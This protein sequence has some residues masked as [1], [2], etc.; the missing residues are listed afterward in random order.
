VRR[1]P[2]TGTI[3]RLARGWLARLP[4]EPRTHLGLFSTYEEAEAVLGAA[5]EAMAQGRVTTGRTLL[6]YGRHVLDQRELDGYRG[7]GRERR[8]WENYV[9]TWDAGARPVGACTR[10]VIRAWVLELRGRLA[11]Q[12]VANALN[13]LR[14]VLRRAVEDDLVDH[15]AA[16]DVDLRRHGRTE[17][18]ST[19]LT[20]AELE[21]LLYASDPEGRHLIAVA[22]WTGMRQGEVRSLRVQDVSLE[23][24]SPHL[25]V[26]HGS[27]GKPTKS[28][29]IRRVPLFGRALVALQS[30]K[31]PANDRG[32]VFPTRTGAVRCA[33]RMVEPEDWR[34]WLK[35]ARITRHVRWHDLRHTCATLLLRGELTPEPWSL[36]AVKELLGH[37]S[38]QVTERYAKG[39]GSLAEKSARAVK[40]P[41]APNLSRLRDLNS[42][43]TVYESEGNVS[44]REVLA[45]I[46]ALLRRGA[47]RD[48]VDAAAAYLDRVHG[49]DVPVKDG[50]G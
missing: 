28:G 49:V 11:H 24:A 40:P 4:D 41:E 13:L 10:K 46:V 33:G 7:V 42:R 27:P 39:D 43:P 47:T 19:T 34:R 23:G 38:L 1:T 44:D 48:V 5:L 30:W 12:T 37:S 25:V 20:R 21:A 36:E 22:A 9:G 15:N 16:R 50:A 6:A 35:A 45:A 14:A 18:T 29:K 8:A 2:G 32:L 26:R 3:E 17:D 31:P